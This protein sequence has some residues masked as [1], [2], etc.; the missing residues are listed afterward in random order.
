MPADA[1]QQRDDGITPLSFETFAGVNTATERAGV[2]DQQ[3]YWLDGMMPLA[4]RRLRTLPGIGAALYTAATAGNVLCFYFYNIGSTP[5]CAIFQNDGSLIQVNTITGAQTT[6]LTAGS[7]I[8][9]TIPSVGT[10]QYGQQYLL[11]VANQ[12]NGYW[13]WDGSVLYGA[14]TLA[15]G[16]I[17]TNGGA[18]YVSPP[19]VTANGGHGHGATFV[20]T[21]AG[22]IVTNVFIT[23]AG[24]GYLSGD[25]VSLT[26]TGGTQTGSGATVTASLTSVAG[27]SGGSIGALWSIVNNGNPWLVPMPSIVAA[28]SGYGSLVA[29]SFTTFSMVV[30][31]FQWVNSGVPAVQ[32]IE[33]SGT[34]S[35]AT[36][37]PPSNNPTAAFNITDTYEIGKAVSL[38]AVGGTLVTI[39]DVT[40][41]KAANNLVFDGTNPGS[42]PIGTT[43]IMTPTVTSTLLTLSNAIVGS[44][45]QQNDQIFVIGTSLLPAISVNDSGFFYVGSVS[46]IDAGTGYGPNV[47]ISVASGGAP[48]V[49]AVLTPVLSGGTTGSLVSVFINNGGI[50]GSNTP[51]TLTVTDSASA[52]AGTI[53]LM[54]FGIQGTAAQTYAGHVWVFNG[55]VFNFS[56]PGSVS[57]FATSAGGGS[58]QSN[59][60]YLKVGYTGAVSANGFLFLIGDSSMDYISGVVTSGSV[61]T[62]TFTQNNSDPDVGTPYAAAITTLGS[63]IFI[64]NA[65]GIFVSSGGTFQKISEPMDGVYNTVPAAQFNANPFNGFQLSVAKATIFGKRVWMALVPIIDPVSG[66]SVNKLL[67]VRDKKIWWAAQQDVTLTFIQGQEINSVYTAYGTDGTHIYPLFNQPSSGFKKTAQSRLWDDPGG[68]D[69]AKAT[70]RWW[71][72]WYA[73]STVST[74][75]SLTID[76][77]GIDASGNQYTNSQGYSIAGP[78]AIG[79]YISQPQG[80]GQQGVFTGMTIETQ[81]ADI[82]LIA[83][84]MADEVVGQ[85]S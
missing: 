54:P 69:F 4:Q 10:S 73:N 77:V 62:T 79:Y 30:S 2:P 34:L 83:A 40:I 19:T 64:A 17:L 3:A 15:P 46:I 7:I 60:S 53:T 42:I 63:E 38:A 45:V 20:A 81:A 23:S 72:T 78:T 48:L 5:Y 65:T 85:R 75:I 12:T 13:V 57:D 37:S 18:G 21:V 16:V 50:Y 24:T 74:S 26:F 31:N 70:S 35:A 43:L 49:Q 27:G 80:V 71:S 1:K 25:S 39:S 55:N 59:S 28:G 6:I 52:A 51:P 8:N 84:K 76:A 68:I 47:G 82:E 32:P 9:P 22:G 41:F 66:L 44:G 29:A 56:A 36:I 33:V 11:A 58:D 61:A 14:G 67:M